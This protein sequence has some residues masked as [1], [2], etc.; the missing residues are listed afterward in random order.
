MRITTSNVIH[1]FEA[2]QQRLSADFPA[3]EFSLGIRSGSSTYVEVP[4]ETPQEIFTMIQA[5]LD[6]FDE[7]LDSNK[8]PKQ[9]QREQLQ[10][11]LANALASAE[12]KAVT[13]L[14]ETERTALLQALAYKLG[15][16]GQAGT[17]LS[18]ADWLT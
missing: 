1:N 8:T 9:L 12:G 4:D 14:S 17:L 7:T 2:L 5:L 16:V 10:A 13:G 18:T 11:A 3:L 6:T 15:A